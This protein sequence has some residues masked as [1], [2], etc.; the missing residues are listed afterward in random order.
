MKKKMLLLLLVM[1]LGFVSFSVLNPSKGFCIFCPSNPCYGDYNCGDCQCVRYDYV[2]PG[3][4][5]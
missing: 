3:R 2:R 5:Q 4:C 1:I